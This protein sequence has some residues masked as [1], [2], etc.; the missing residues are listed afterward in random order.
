MTTRNT[1]LTGLVASC[2][3][4]QGCAS[5]VGL[6]M[7]GIGGGTATNVGVEHTL[8]GISYK[9]FTASVDQVHAANR[10]ALAGMSV[11]ITEDIK[12]DTGRSLKAQAADREIEIQFERL[13]PRLTRM[14]VVASENLLFKDSATATEIIL[15]TA[16]QLDTKLAAASPRR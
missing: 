8:N 12:T 15:Q 4:L 10:Q 2:L 5:G 13:T 16:D 6:T 3:A 14:R 9:T 11:K 7:L 1:M